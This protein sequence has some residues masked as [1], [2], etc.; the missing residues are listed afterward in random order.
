MS[1]TVT[2]IA[3]N[4]DPILLRQQLHALIQM[5]VTQDRKGNDTLEGIIN[6]IENMLDNYDNNALANQTSVGTE[7]RLAPS[8]ASGTLTGRIEDQLELYQAITK[9]I[10]DEKFNTTTN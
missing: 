1:N 2:L 4:I 9:V 8:G 7:K 5:Q 3:I 10:S 6:M